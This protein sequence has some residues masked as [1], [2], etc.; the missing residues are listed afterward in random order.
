MADR[1]MITILNCLGSI[2]TVLEWIF[3]CGVAGLVYVYVG[4]PLIVLALSRMLSAKRTN[5]SSPDYEPTV[6]ILIAAYNESRHITS[7][8]LNKLELEYPPAKLDVIVISDESDDGTD[9]L[10]TDLNSPRVR[11]LR[12]VPRAG[13]TAALNLAM[14]QVDSEIVVFSDANSLYAADALRGLLAVLVDPAIGYVTGR[15]VYKSEDGLPT[16]EGCSAYMRYE[17][18]LRAWETNLGSVVGVDGGIDAMR[19]NLY[20]P[21]RP[22]QL[23]DFVQPLTVREQ[24]YRVVYT[25][26][27]LLY[28]DA[29]TTVEDEFK[30]RVRVGL[31]A[32]HALKD[33]ANLFNPFRFAWFSWQLLSHKLLRYLG[34]IFQLLAL[35]SNALLAFD[36]TFWQVLLAGQTVFYLLAFWGYFRRRSELPRLVTLCYYLCVVNIAS[37][38]ALIHFLRGRKQVIWKPRT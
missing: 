13:K 34:G 32:W 2:V 19:R 4:Y 36:S 17:N 25:P 21:M 23:P 26:D 6:T 10:V 30:M 16:G 27:A 12:Q 5:L 38:L 1:G 28:E 33:K 11:L 35:V 37:G 8:V 22:D 14:Q 15:M 9:E 31:R 24:G 20:R 29:L 18:T 3:C 7:T